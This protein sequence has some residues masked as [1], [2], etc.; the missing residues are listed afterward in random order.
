M[1]WLTYRQPNAETQTVIRPLV[2]D[3]QLSSES[4]PY[5][6]VQLSGPYGL[7]LF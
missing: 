2:R 7:D 6:V 3:D 1:F 4:L 5:V